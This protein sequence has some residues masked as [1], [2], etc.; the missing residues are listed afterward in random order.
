M[1][2][3]DCRAQPPL[4]ELIPRGAADPAEASRTVP[5]GRTGLADRCSS[6]LLVARARRAGMIE[7]IAP[8]PSQ[9]PSTAHP[10]HVPAEPVRNRVVARR[11]R[12][13][14]RCPAPP[15]SPAIPLPL[16]SREW[17]RVERRHLRLVLRLALT[18]LVAIA[19]LMLALLVLYRWVDP[20]ASTLMLGQRLAGTP[21]SQRWVP[22]ERISPNLLGGRD[23]VR[24][25]PLLP[26]PRRRLGRAEGGHRER[27][28]RHRARR[29]HHLHAGGQEPVPVAVAELR[30]QGDRDTAGL[31]HGG[32]MAQAAHPRDLPQ[33]RR[34]GARHL[35][36]GGGSALPLQEV[37]PA[38]QPRARPRC[39]PSRSPTPSSGRPAGPALARCASPTTCCCA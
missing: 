26:P 21:I 10:T 30:A 19:G 27:R 39:S 13:R 35:R 8:Q 23:L 38:A 15:P 34:V 3:G 2:T 6:S 7:P 32:A 4:L 12:Q 29:Q 17:P 20:P 18:L 28:R 14:G 31:R 24:G 16:P 33:Y 25:R 37:R 36:R 1:P 22:L 5:L 11:A 9:L